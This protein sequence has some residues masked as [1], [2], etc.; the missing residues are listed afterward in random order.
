MMKIV[1]V[2]YHD[3]NKEARSM[4]MLKCLETI[5]K[6]HLVSYVTPDN[7]DDVDVNLVDKKSPIALFLFLKLAKKVL[8]RVSPDIIV[9]HD[10]DCSVLLPFIK[11]KLP[12]STL[13][14]DSSE[15]YI[16]GDFSNN[17]KLFG[18]DGFLIWVKQ[19]ITKFRSKYEKKYLKYADLVFAANVE[20]A[21]I[22]KDYFELSET[23]SIFDNI[24]RID[25]CYDEKVCTEKYA[26]F[27]EN[28]SFNIL[29]AGGISEERK[30]FDYIKAFSR[31]DK[32]VKLNIVGSASSVALKQYKCLIKELDIED[33]VQYWGFVTRA[34]LRYL[35][36]K[37][38]ASVVIFDM[39]SYNTLY[40]ESG[41]CYESLFEGTP[42]LASEN[43]PL[44]RLCEKN[45]IGV[46]DN[47]YD[48]GILRLME[49]YSD[50][51]ESVTE[52][53]RSIDYDGRINRLA[54][55]IKSKVK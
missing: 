19:K 22:M 2:V 8:L 3:L 31:V 6:V 52:Y 21:N 44:K 49:N 42:I 1:Y 16:R 25:D 45:M 10:S 12:N 24:H 26:Q 29:F 23:P 38:H 37:S 55:Q 54:Q 36:Q 11:K 47:N 39:D 40:C 20:R 41:K 43:P 14:Y 30:T 28:D 15:L 48:E 35:M 5:G 9:L 17:R 33:K 18:N 53:V 27:F 4:E 34:E 32:N 13:V 7:S 51:V 46:S 50:Y